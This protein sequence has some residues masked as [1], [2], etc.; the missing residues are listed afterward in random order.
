MTKFEEPAAFLVVDEQ[1]S[2]R[3]LYLGQ[4]DAKRAARNLLAYRV[5]CKT[6]RVEPLYLRLNEEATI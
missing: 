4:D 6:V 5:G 3:S 2:R 1:D